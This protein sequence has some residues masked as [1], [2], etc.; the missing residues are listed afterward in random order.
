MDK[1]KVLEVVVKKD[2]EH[3]HVDRR[4]RMLK[5]LAE[6]GNNDEDRDEEIIGR[7]EALKFLYEV[8]CFRE[9]FGD[10]HIVPELREA[11]KKNE[12]FL[13]IRKQQ[14]YRKEPARWLVDG[15]KQPPQFRDNNKTEHREM[16]DDDEKCWIPIFDFTTREKLVCEYC[17][18]TECQW[19]KDNSHYYCLSAPRSR[20]RKRHTTGTKPCIKHQFYL[21]YV[22]RDDDEGYG[23]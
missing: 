13:G 4:I 10:D 16:F 1:E 7:K 11:I 8:E 5:H 9:E 18:C 23:Y 2:E 21:P 15:L 22:E 17:S 6:L 12:E 3:K 20:Q 14:T 19:E